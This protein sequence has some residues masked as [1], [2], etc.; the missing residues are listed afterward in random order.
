MLPEYSTPQKVKP[1]GKIGG[2]KST[3]LSPKQRFA[4]RKLQRLRD[5]Q[6]MSQSRLYSRIDFMCCYPRVM[7]LAA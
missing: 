4:E 6:A 2:E 3:S 5:K 1:E 7:S